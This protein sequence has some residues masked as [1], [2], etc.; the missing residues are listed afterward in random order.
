MRY[1][2]LH[3][4]ASGP[5]SR[6]AQFF[7]QK[8]ESAGIT[9]EIPALDEGNF[10]HLTISGQLNLIGRILDG[11]PAILM[12]SSMGGYLAALYASRHPEIDRMVLLAP[13]FGFSARWEQTFGEEKV[14][15]WRTHGYAEVYHYASGGPRR[16]SVDLLTDSA[17]HDP[18]PACPQPTLIFHGLQDNVVPLAAAERWARE[19]PRTRLVPLNSGHELLDVLEPVW[20][21]SSPFLTAACGHLRG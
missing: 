7:R 10:E 4:F 18:Y 2:Y 3:G 6:K 8:L 12:G 19:N 5:Q 9:L 21:E 14:T 13:A 1:L 15:A 11:Q 16:L 17:Q 20:D